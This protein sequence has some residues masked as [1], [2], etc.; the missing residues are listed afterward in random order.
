MNTLVLDLQRLWLS[1]HDDEHLI[2]CIEVQGRHVCRRCAVLYPIALLVLGAIAV[3]LSVPTWT[4]FV[5]PIPAVAEFIAETRGLSYVPRRQVLLTAIAA[6]ALGLGF[7]RALDNLFDGALWTMVALSVVPCLVA[8]TIRA[9][10][11]QR[12][13]RR[14]R[15][16]GE[17]NHPLL[18]GFGSAQEFQRYLDA[19]GEA[20]AGASAANDRPP[21][22]RR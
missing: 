18:K 10:E 1:H 8:A 3:G 21:T 22:L 9:H 11:E 14:I 5:L 19:A 16:D 4:L 12:V 15:K 2:R 7:S 6:P 20:V 17:E 13:A